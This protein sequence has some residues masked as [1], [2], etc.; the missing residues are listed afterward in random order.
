MGKCKPLL[1]VK[2]KTER[3]TRDITA[4]TDGE[5]EVAWCTETEFLHYLRDCI[6]KKLKDDGCLVTWDNFAA[7]S[8]EA[9]K[10]LCTEEK[11]HVL[12][13][14]PN[15]TPYI[16]PLDV[17]VNRPFKAALKKMFHSWTVDNI[18][19]VPQTKVGRNEIYKWSRDSWKEMNAGTIQRSFLCCGFGIPNEKLS[20]DNINL[21]VS[22]SVAP[23]PN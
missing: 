8:T 21:L 23:K 20:K 15:C 22:P 6:P 19:K 4:K 16:Q 11:L 17:A 14:P 18:G 13:L 9:V 1:I 10:E 3:V 7:H 2:G 5:I 12:E